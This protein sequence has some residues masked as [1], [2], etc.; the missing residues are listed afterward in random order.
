MAAERIFHGIPFDANEIITPEGESSYDYIYYSKDLATWLATYFKNGILVPGGALIT[1]QLKVEKSN[2]EELL[3]NPGNI[4]INGR[5]GFLPK[6]YKLAVVPETSGNNRIDRVVVELNLNETVN[7]FRFVLLKGTASATPSAPELTRDEDAKIYQ[8]SLAQVIVKSTGIFSIT[9][10][11][12]SDDLCG[13]SQVL[14]GVRVPAP[15][16]GDSADNISYDNSTTGMSAVTVQDVIDELYEGKENKP[17]YVDYTLSASLW[18]SSDGTYSLESIFAHTLYNI[19]VLT[20]S[21]M[22]KEQAVAYGKA[23]IVGNKSTNVLKA[24]GDIPDVNIPI[25]LEVTERW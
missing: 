17:T 6:S 25:I 1:T 12:S 15:E 11:R 3:I 2:D 5:T 13:I 9:D 8:M 14:I 16:T 10:E 20:S 24:L 23:M 19:G 7:E 21:E 22:T 4:V 18:S